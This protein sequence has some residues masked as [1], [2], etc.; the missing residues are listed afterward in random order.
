MYFDVIHFDQRL[1]NL[2]INGDVQNG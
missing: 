2:K 1:K